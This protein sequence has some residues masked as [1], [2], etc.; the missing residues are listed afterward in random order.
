MVQFKGLQ[1]EGQ[2]MGSHGSVLSYYNGQFS[3][4]SMLR[5]GAAA[6]VIIYMQPVWIP[7]SNGKVLLCTI[8]ERR[9]ERTRDYNRLW[10]AAFRNFTHDADAGCWRRVDPY[11]RRTSG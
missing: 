8:D 5:C 1:A 9:R 10:F 2:T 3:S 4:H 7:R 11:R 6:R